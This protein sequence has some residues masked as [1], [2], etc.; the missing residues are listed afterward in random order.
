[1][2]SDGKGQQ[3]KS[4]SLKH[5][6]RRDDSSSDDTA[7]SAEEMLRRGEE[8]YRLLFDSISEGFCIIEVLFDEQALAK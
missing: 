3:S 6:S 5:S 7:A 2:S 1:M 4:P 8:R